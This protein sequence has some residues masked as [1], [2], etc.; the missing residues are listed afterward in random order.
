MMKSDKLYSIHYCVSYVQAYPKYTDTP[1]LMSCEKLK[2]N[3]MSIHP[4]RYKVYILYIYLQEK[5]H[6]ETRFK[7][8]IHTALHPFNC[9]ANG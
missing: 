6:M 9:T 8:I 3:N 1:T 7:Y 4:I 2:E 5:L